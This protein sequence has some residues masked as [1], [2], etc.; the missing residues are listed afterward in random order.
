MSLLQLAGRLNLHHVHRRI[1]RLY[2]LD[3]L[4]LAHH[5][6]PGSDAPKR[7]VAPVQEARVVR[8]LDQEATVA[9]AR[10]AALAR[11]DHA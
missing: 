3:A 6:H 4:N 2:D 5:I 9:H 11:V 10:A 1:L 8:Q 7:L